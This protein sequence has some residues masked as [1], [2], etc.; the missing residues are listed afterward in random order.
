MNLLKQVQVTVTLFCA[1][2][3]KNSKTICMEAENLKNR[4][5]FM[6]THL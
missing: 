5:S 1:N 2:K 6:L 3:N 4:S